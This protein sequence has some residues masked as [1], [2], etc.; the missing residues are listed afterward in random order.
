[1]TD[2]SAS[3][4][5]DRG[6]GCG[7]GWRGLAAAL[8]LLA[9][10]ACACGQ[11]TGRQGAY[12]RLDPTRLT[13]TLRSLGM[14]ELMDA[15]IK[16][17]IA[18]GRP[19]V[20]PG[21]LAALAEQKISDAK[22]SPDPA[23]RAKLLQ[24]AIEHYQTLAKR[25]EQQIPKAKAGIEREEHRWK[26]YEARLRVAEI[27]RI[28]VEPIGLR[29]M[30]LQG[31]QEDRR[32]IAQL[33]A[34]PVRIVE[35]L[36]REIQNTMM[37][38]RARPD[39]GPLVVFTLRH[40]VAFAK[41][42]EASAYLKLYRGMALSE[43]IPAEAGQRKTVLNEVV[44]DAGKHL[45]APDGSGVQHSAYL[46]M[47]MAMRELKQ[48][49]QAAD[50]LGKASGEKAPPVVRLQAMFEAVRNRI[51]QGRYDAVLPGI[52]QFKTTASQ[53]VGPG[54]QQ[55]V[56][57]LVAFLKNHFYDVRA[58]RQTAPAKVKADRALAQKALLEFLDKYDDP[59]VSTAFLSYVG[60]KYR[61]RKDRENLSGIVLVALARIERSRQTPQ[62]TAEAEKL[63]SLAEKTMDDPA[64]KPAKPHVLWEMGNVLYELKRLDEAG[65][66]FTDYA[67]EFPDRKQAYRAA[68]NGVICH[69][70]VTTG[71]T[72]DQ[73]LSGYIRALEVLL[74]KWGDKPEAVKWHFDLGK[75]CQLVA[76]NS[77]GKEQKEYFLKAV[78]AFDKVPPNLPESTEAQQRA[79]DIRMQLL[80]ADPTA[81]DAFQQA[82]VLVSRMNAFAAK[83]KKDSAAEKDA[84]TSKQ[85]WEWSGDTAFGAIQVLYQFLD[86]QDAA[87]Q[88]LEKLYMEYKDYTEMIRAAMS[89][90][91]QVLVQSGDAAKIARA[92]KRAQEYR[93]QFPKEAEKLFPHIIDRIRERIGE[94]EDKPEG[95][96]ERTRLANAY[97]EFSRE[98]LDRARQTDPNDIYPEKQTYADA[99]V[100]A[101][102]GD[103]AL[104]LWK[105]CQ[106]DDAKRAQAHNRKV[107]A[108]INGLL[109]QLA[110][111]ARNV[112]KLR[113]MV[114]TYMEML[115]KKGLKQETA[116]TR[117]LTAALGALEKST[118][119]ADREKRMADLAEK[120][121][122]ALE[123]MRKDLQGQAS[124]D[125]RNIQGLARANRVLKQ[126]KQA[127]EHYHDLASR[128]SRKDFP[129]QYWAVN[130]ELCQAA[131]EGFKAGKLTKDDMRRL[132]AYIKQLGAED[133][134]MGGHQS[135]FNKIKA[136][137]EKAA[138]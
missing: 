74:G 21:D 103:E 102:R 87:L 91:I 29:L 113:K 92:I 69:S 22:A 126:Y 83:V 98:L 18:N 46:L 133:S 58:S 94:L 84:A 116:H 106:A 37:E 62:G 1:M 39:K 79:L 119:A 117:L 28:L 56:D 36:R 64:N 73:L 132:V 80:Q 112:N 107:D 104:K 108:E 88:E 99:L 14:T 41:L 136:D 131:L 71:R 61:D 47:G 5:T 110:D 115:G 129:K 130:L 63:L 111:A 97:L 55:Q 49:D 7:T 76:Q 12:R 43:E 9:G 67:A 78:A 75:Q 11:P 2:R 82:Q 40:Q 65:R 48:H 123:V 19:A 23:E 124:V 33:T 35:D 100:V 27:Y 96:Q 101:G 85:L 50:A 38:Y 30:Y 95:Q 53:V 16:Q 24:E 51:E 134:H 52:E 89:W 57:V 121:K 66:R 25:E 120:L 81:S 125:A 60:L 54:G 32:H 128:I 42:D 114:Q 31:A 6:L 68:L 118:D 13:E 20:R 122:A 77:E 127:M 93:K 17:H 135:K 137:A 8:V 72:I 3:V 10:A 45:Q 109:D 26:W 105:D 4:G 90:E 15:H 138:K 59:G 70:Q 86:Q 44:T 34:E